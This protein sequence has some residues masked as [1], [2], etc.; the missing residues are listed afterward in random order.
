MN[1]GYWKLYTW[2][3]FPILVHWT[4]LLWLPWYWS[5]N[6]SLTWSVITFLAYTALLLAHEFGH[7]FAASL[8]RLRVHSIRLYLMHGLCQ[9]Q[10]PYSEKDHIFIAWGGVLAQMCVLVLALA[11]QFATGIFLPGTEYLMAPI[12]FVFIKANLVTAA[13][14][15]IPVA[16][17]DGHLAWRAFP[18]LWCKLR[19]EIKSRPRSEGNVIDFQKRRVAARKSK[20]AAEDLIDKLRNK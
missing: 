17:L 12:F 14:N 1:Q 15:L 7:A 5:Q 6:K 2:K 3:N 11:A 13:F 19:T 10:S 8:C 9:F 4:I 20:R 18:L 16:P